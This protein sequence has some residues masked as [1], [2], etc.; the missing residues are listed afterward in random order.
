[1]EPILQHSSKGQ[2]LL[3]LHHALFF[4][5]PN[6]CVLTLSALSQLGSFGLIPST[7]YWDGSKPDCF[8]IR[9]LST[10]VN[11]GHSKRSNLTRP[12]QNKDL[13][14]YGPWRVL[15][16]N[17]ICGLKRFCCMEWNLSWAQAE[18]Q[19]C[20]SLDSLYTE[21]Y[22]SHRAGFISMMVMLCD[23]NGQVVQA[24]NLAQ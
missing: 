19:T 1:M 11:P 7:S 15:T 5:L 4:V 17:T 13:L 2:C 3:L 21:V 14:C 8:R 9:L 24:V 16:S 6:P 22:W 20:C 23:R 10:D 12:C 18:T